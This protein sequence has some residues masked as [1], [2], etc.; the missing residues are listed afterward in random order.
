MESR[1]LWSLRVTMLTTSGRISCMVMQLRPL[2]RTGAEMGRRV[3]PSRLTSSVTADGQA[4]RDKRWK[5]GYNAMF[6]SM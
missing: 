2:V 5:K 3:E 1:G 4:E 6:S